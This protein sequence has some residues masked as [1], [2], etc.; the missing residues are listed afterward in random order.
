M[1]KQTAYGILS[2]F[3][4]LYLAATFLKPPDPEAMER[5]GL[6][7]LQLRLLLVSI[8][9]PIIA[10]WY[11]ALYGVVHYYAYAKIVKNSPEGPGFNALALGLTILFVGLIAGTVVNLLQQAVEA[12][13]PDLADIQKIST[14]TRNYINVIVYFTAFM[15]MMFGADRL[16]RAFNVALNYK[17]AMFATYLP[18]IVISGT[19][20][21]L[22]FQNSYRTMSDNPDINPTYYL[23]DF[24][25]VFTIVLPYIVSWLLA[26][27]ALF[28]LS[29]FY[30]NISGTVYKKSLKYF[31]LGL[32]A[33]V[34]LTVFLQVVSQIGSTLVSGGL[35]VILIF[36]YFILALIAAGYFLVARGAK[37]LKKIEEV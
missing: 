6:S 8:V 10:V 2:V 34:T 18:S 12:F 9:I 23:S 29:L 7:A 33:V 19:Y 28:N 15:Y 17:K 35:G 22:L 1:K 21:Y 37:E 25:I 4:L 24:M 5:F 13:F 36:I 20:I 26:F 31:T 16:V 30:Q 11:M 3:V 27:S 14:I 32:S